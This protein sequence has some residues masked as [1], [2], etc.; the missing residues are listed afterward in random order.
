MTMF[1]KKVF[2][3]SV[4]VLLVVSLLAWGCNSSTDDPKISENLVTVKSANP[5]EA[6]VDVDGE[7]VDLDEDGTKETTVFESTDQ[8]ISF[9]SRKR[10]D[11]VGEFSDVIFTR[12]EI[13]YELNAGTPPPTRTEGLTITVPAGGTASHGMT[14]VLSTDVAAGYFVLGAQGWVHL[15]F[16]GRD[17]SGKPADAE[18]QFQI[19]TVTACGG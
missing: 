18:G 19:R 8:T 2:P 16:T 15:R 4:L 5:T 14:T 10:V 6:C 17:A 9:D 11:G 13:S 3:L 12:V 7:L 1:A